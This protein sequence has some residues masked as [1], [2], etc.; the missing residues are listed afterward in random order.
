MKRRYSGNITPQ[1]DGKSIKIAGWVHDIRD[2]GKLRFILIRDRDGVIQVT[3]PKEEVSADVFSKSREVGREWV[4]EIEGIVKAIEKAPN[5]YEILPQ[6]I[7]ILNPSDSPLPLDP[8]G[9]VPADLDTR[10]DNRILDLRRPDNLGILKLRSE[11]L[12]SIREFFL[13]N[14]FVEVNTPKLVASATEGGTELFPI[15]YFE[16]EAF[17]GQSPQLYKQMLMAS[18][19]DRVF[20]IAQIFRAEEHNTRKHL[21]EAVS[22]DA[23]AAF[24]DEEDVMGILENLIHFTYSK[25]IEKH[26]NET[27]LLKSIVVPSLPFERIPYSDAIDDLQSHDIGI[28]WG[29][30]FP[31][32]AEKKLGELHPDFY[33]VTDWPT[34]IKPFYTMPK[35]EGDICAAFDLMYGE[36]ELASG[37]KRVHDYRLLKE[38]I[39]AK[40]LNPQ[41]F[42]F[43]LDV[44]RYGMPPHA[45]WGLGLDRLMMVLTGV[46]NIREV[47]IFPRDR[48]RLTP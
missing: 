26:E 39:E 5:G 38:R 37:T 42:T 2:L 24:C 23:E 44:F 43:Y 4:V 6:K 14:D 21:N 1:M 15:S 35:K 7:E 27:A 32:I 40:G 33:F 10:L 22:I 31:S 34:E 19:L 36:T 13:N 12:A 46:K 9:K 29:E 17:L 47:V 41:N 25:I 11:I 45:G 8:T 28:Q 48:K 16:R 30:D 18:G 3:L 20:E